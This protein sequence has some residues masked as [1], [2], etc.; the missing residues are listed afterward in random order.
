[1][2]HGLF[3]P[4]GG[5]ANALFYLVKKFKILWSDFGRGRYNCRILKIFGFFELSGS[6][7]T[8]MSLFWLRSGY[9]RK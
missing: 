1:M 3:W 4:G 2:G 7:R 9:P 5:Y 8:T 6:S